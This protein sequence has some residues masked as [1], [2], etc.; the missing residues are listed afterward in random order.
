ML[1]AA[2]SCMGSEVILDVL[3]LM[4][5]PGVEGRI[6]VRL[7]LLTRI[8]ML[9]ISCSSH[10]KSSLRTVLVASLRSFSF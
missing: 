9:P 1:T 2:D 3:R 8:Q 4:I 10:R 7:N 5:D 6:G